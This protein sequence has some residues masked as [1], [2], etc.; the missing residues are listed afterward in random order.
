VLV[1][2]L[3]YEGRHKIDEK[4]E[5]Q[6]YTVTAQPDLNIPVYGV[7]SVIGSTIF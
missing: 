4:F 7:R 1:K 5:E 2:I 3:A 6:P